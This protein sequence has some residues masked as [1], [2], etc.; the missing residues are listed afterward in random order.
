MKRLTLISLLAIF[1]FSSCQNEN[2]ILAPESS[3]TEY[4]IN[5]EPNWFSLPSSDTFS[6]QKSF[7]REEWVTVS[8]GGSLEVDEEYEGGPFG[9]VDV[10]VNITFQPG[11]L[12][13]DTYITMI[14]NDNTFVFDFSP[15]MQ[16]N[17]PAILNVKLVGVDLSGLDMETFDF[18]YL[19]YDGT[20]EVM[21]YTSL[22]ID[23]LTGTLE[24][25]DAEIPHFSRFGVGK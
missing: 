12:D 6:L 14:A 19:A 25:V 23:E 10:F 15:S 18:Y 5:N 2:S 7:T 24:L 3:E 1:I 13:Q 20:Y 21:Q 22:T 9:E 11:A 16:F 4:S 17:S 8:N